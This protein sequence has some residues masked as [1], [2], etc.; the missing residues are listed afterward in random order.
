MLDLSCG[1]RENTITNVQTNTNHGKYQ[2]FNDFLSSAE[3]VFEDIE[4]DLVD[5]G[6]V[7]VVENDLNLLLQPENMNPDNTQYYSDDFQCNVELGSNNIVDNSLELN[8]FENNMVVCN[9][10]L[11]ND[12]LADVEFLNL[13]K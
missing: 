3:F 1:N 2:T 11:Q 5:L 13:M 8:L 9:E 12:S 7:N 4:T 10:N 6:N